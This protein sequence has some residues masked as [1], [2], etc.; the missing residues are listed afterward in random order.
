MA[1]DLSIAEGWHINA[2]QPLQKELIATELSLAGDGGGWQ[3][4][5]CEYP[6]PQ[7]VR[8]SFQQEELAVYLGT[9]HLRADFA[10]GEESPATG[11]P[12]LPVKVRIQACNNEMCLR[13][14]E[15]VLEVPTAQP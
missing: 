6:E 4:R 7:R 15:L 5:G 12:V 14:E 13:P 1:V 2:H 11:V 8:L 9:V 10:Q 3:L